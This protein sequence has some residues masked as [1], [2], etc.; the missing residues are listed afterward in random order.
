MGRETQ[1]Q[2]FHFQ[3]VE[4]RARMI[5]E[6]EDYL[7]LRLPGRGAQWP[8]DYNDRKAGSGQRARQW[9]GKLQAS[10]CWPST[11]PSFG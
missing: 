1:M 7:A 6:T 8:R 2:S 3:T 4:L 10:R 5:R 11:E 9:G